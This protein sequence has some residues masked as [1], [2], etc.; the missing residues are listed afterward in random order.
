MKATLTLSLDI[1]IINKLKQEK[2]YSEL[3]NDQII[4]FYKSIET[5]DKAKLMQNL[6]ETKQI[7][8]ENRKKQREIEKKL[9][10]VKQNEQ[11][12]LEACKGKTVAERIAERRRSIIYSK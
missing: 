2:N 7:L 3:V 4:A 12:V 11:K 8:K 5:P 9:E 10:K 6:K 1:E